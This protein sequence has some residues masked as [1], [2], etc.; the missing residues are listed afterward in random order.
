MLVGLNVARIACFVPGCA[1][2]YCCVLSC[3]VLS[4]LVYCA[5]RE[6]LLFVPGS[7]VAASFF[8]LLVLVS[9]A[10]VVYC[11]GRV[12]WVSLPLRPAACCCLYQLFRFIIVVR[13]ARLLALLA[14]AVTFI[15]ATFLF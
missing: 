12:V 11:C 7:V 5:W 14:F 9:V 4:F 13:I 15:V 3:L 2:L 10:A 1:F 8:L 6:R